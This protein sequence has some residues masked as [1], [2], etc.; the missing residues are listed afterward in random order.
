MGFFEVT[1]A[2]KA[3][4]SKA[5]AQDCFMIAPEIVRITF[6]GSFDFREVLLVFSSH[7]GLDD[8]A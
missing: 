4:F 7:Q 5:F 2:V 6:K 8:L 3:D 1:T